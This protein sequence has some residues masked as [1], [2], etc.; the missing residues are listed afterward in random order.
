MKLLNEAFDIIN[1]PMK[2]MVYDAS[3]QQMRTN[4]GSQTA[5]SQTKQ[6]QYTYGQRQAHQEWGQQWKKP[7]VVGVSGRS[8]S[9]KGVATETLA[10]ANYNV[11]LLQ[12]DYYFYENTPCTYKGYSC[13]EHVNC[14]DFDRL[15]RDVEFLERGKEIIIRTPTWMSRTEVSISYE[16]LIEKSLIIVDG[17]LTFTVKK[18]VDIFDYKIFVDAS[19]YNILSRRPMRD[20][21]AAFNYVRDVV[22]PVSKEYERIQKES[23][24]LIVDGDSS[25]N[26]VVRKIVQALQGKLSGTGI[27]VTLPFG[28]SPWKVHLGDLV[29]D[30]VWH[31]IDFGDLKQWVKKEKDRLDNG[32]ELK[33]HTFRYRKNLQTGTYE[34]R[35][36]TLHKPR[37]CRYNREPT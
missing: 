22:I 6:T 35:L 8:C 17:F 29:Q 15:I 7:F 37:I 9:G 24:D 34:V 4:S 1:D 5:D 21:F 23:A 19:D 10:S 33:G 13:W 28:Q 20:G 12:S 14:I 2:R 30:N 18:L 16:D 26:E 3:Y 27:G 36:S 25:K 31:P 32:E 11:L